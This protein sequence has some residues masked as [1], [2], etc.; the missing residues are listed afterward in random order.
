MELS[1]QDLTQAQFDFLVAYEAER[2]T[3]QAWLSAAEALGARQADLSPGSVR[4]LLG[5][6]A[7]GQPEMAAA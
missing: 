5:L 7:D 1:T 6:L 4:E 2:E 3:R